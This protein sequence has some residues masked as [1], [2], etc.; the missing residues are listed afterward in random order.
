[1]P[2]CNY[3]AAM[4]I[5]C[6]ETKGESALALS[7]DLGVHYKTGFLRAHKIRA[8]MAPELKGMTVGGP[9]RTA[10]VDGGYFGVESGAH[11]AKLHHSLRPYIKTE[12]QWA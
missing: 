11:N 8:A 9:G 12:D 3:L 2:L 5:F 10:E 7:R 4:A 6:N 1:M